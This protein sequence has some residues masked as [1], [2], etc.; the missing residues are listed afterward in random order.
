MNTAVFWDVP[1][2]GLIINRR[3]FVHVISSTLKI[4][5]TRSSVM[6]VYNEPTR[7]SSVNSCLIRKLGNY[8]RVPVMAHLPELLQRVSK[9]KQRER[10]RRGSR[11]EGGSDE[12]YI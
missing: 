9:Y 3:F 6:T 2:C 12:H 7:H 8:V 1:P 10:E 5:A 11:V 4:E